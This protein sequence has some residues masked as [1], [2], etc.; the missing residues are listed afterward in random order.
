[1][2]D[3][4]RP[5]AARRLSLEN[6]LTTISAAEEELAETADQLIAFQLQ[7]SDSQ[8]TQSA[9]PNSS[10]GRSPCS[11]VLPYESPH[12]P[13]DPLFHGS[14]LHPGAVVRQ[15]AGGDEVERRRV[16][17]NHDYALEATVQLSEQEQQEIRDKIYRALVAE[18]MVLPGSPAA[19]AGGSESALQTAAQAALHFALTKQV[20]LCGSQHS[21]H[22]SRPARPG[23]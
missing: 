8:P 22:T 5:P 7:S 11:A 10:I 17:H 15:E 13:A 23:A 12:L 20:L 21:P 16:V 2:A 9:E 3:A 4:D 1:M 6:L 18:R 19:S 14:Q